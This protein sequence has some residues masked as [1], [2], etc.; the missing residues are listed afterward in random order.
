MR[1]KVRPSW[2]VR[3]HARRP[4][5]HERERDA[6]DVVRFAD[7]VAVTRHQI[8]TIEAFATLACCNKPHRRPQAE[9]LPRLLYTSDAAD[10]LRWL[11]RGGRRII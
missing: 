7:S 6:T 8:D 2:P 1:R 11:D 3:L 5:S 4:P 9:L 10:D